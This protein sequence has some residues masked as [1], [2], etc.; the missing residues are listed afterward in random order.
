MMMRFSHAGLQ[1]MT[2]LTP[3]GIRCGYVGV[4]QSH[5]Y[6]GKDR[7]DIDDIEVHGGLTYSG[8]WDD[9]DHT[10]WWLGFDCGHAWDLYDLPTTTSEPPYAFKSNKSQEFVEEETRNLAEQLA[11]VKIK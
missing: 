2:Q 1:C 10:L 3:I 6:Y 7:R 11:R 5:P 4:L 9:L 8:Y